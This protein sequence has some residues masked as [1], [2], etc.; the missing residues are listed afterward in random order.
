MYSLET[1]SARVLW[2]PN[3]KAGQA[4]NMSWE[5]LTKQ[6]GSTVGIRNRIVLCT[7]SITT[8]C[9]ILAGAE[10]PRH[11]GQGL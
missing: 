11:S 8:P 2:N 10:G 7:V 4:V 3:Q 6:I 1:T 5:V 9:V